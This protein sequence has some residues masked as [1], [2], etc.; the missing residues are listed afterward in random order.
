MSGRVEA[1]GREVNQFKPGDQVFGYVS[2]YGG[3]TFAEYVC[4]GEKEIALK[5]VN[6]SSSKLRQFRWR[7]SP[8]YKVYATR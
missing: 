8:H 2:R 5:P 6:L 3:R 7:L 4:A 1:V